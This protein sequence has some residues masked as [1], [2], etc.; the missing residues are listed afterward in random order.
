LRAFAGMMC[1]AATGEPEYAA[2]S[3]SLWPTGAVIFRTLKDDQLPEIVRRILIRSSEELLEHQLQE[4][5]P[6]MNR[7]DAPYATGLAG[8]Y[9]PL[10]IGLCHVQAPD[11]V[12]REFVVSYP[13][14]AKLDLRLK[15]VQVVQQLKTCEGGQHF[16]ELFVQMLAR[17]GRVDDLKQIVS[18]VPDERLIVTTA[19]QAQIDEDRAAAARLAEV[20]KMSG[21]AADAATAPQPAD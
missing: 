4:P 1:Y 16:I 8:G 15:A 18:A 3:L 2:S 21:S 14:V 20:L 12:V 17:Q 10:A 7:L 13:N 9:V 6:G 5:H 11:R 19:V